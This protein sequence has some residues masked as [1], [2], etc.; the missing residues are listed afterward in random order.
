VVT[1]G[2]GVPVGSEHLVE[3]GA[4]GM[5]GLV[6]TGGVMPGASWI[7]T[8]GGP[9]PARKIRREVPSWVKFASVKPGSTGSVTA[10]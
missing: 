5:P 3:R 6:A 8:T 9:L 10:M 7:T 2:A 1:L 4:G